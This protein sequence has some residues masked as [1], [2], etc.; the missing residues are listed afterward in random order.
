[1][2]LPCLLEAAEGRILQHKVSFQQPG[3]LVTKLSDSYSVATAIATKQ[4]V[5]I[6]F[7][8]WITQLSDAGNEPFDFLYS[9]E[10][11]FFR[12]PEISR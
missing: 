9:M 4:E 7:H 8:H 3:W 10:G 2:W 11:D 5:A 1:M 6:A 12:P